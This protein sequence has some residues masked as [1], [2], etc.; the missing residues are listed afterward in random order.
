MPY[1]AP[2]ISKR[3]SDCLLIRLVNTKKEKPKDFLALTYGQLAEV[4]E[5]KGDYQKALIFL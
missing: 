5:R 3:Q 4:Y 1:L 2:E